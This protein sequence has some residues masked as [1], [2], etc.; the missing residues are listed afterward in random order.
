VTPTI[1][2]IIPC[3]GHAE[4]LHGTLRGLLGQEAAKECEIIVVDS[5]FDRHVAAAVGTYPGVTLVRSREGLLP[6]D[7]RNLGADHA[8]G[9]YLAFTDADCI[10]DPGWIASAVA[11]LERGA[12]VV[13]GPVIDLTPT[14]PI[15]AADNLLQF[16]DFPET[17]PNGSATYFPGCNL[18]I[19]RLDFLALGGFPSTPQRAGEDILFCLNVTQRWPDGIQFDHEMRVCH[20]GRAGFGAFLQHHRTFGFARGALGLFLRPVHKRY[21]RWAIVIPLVVLKRLTYIVGR[22]ARWRASALPRVIV[23]S[24]LLVMGLVAW[25]LGF[26]EGLR[27][28]GEEAR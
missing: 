21:G 13:G 2:V 15:G 18:A 22:T 16:V 26:R 23:L 3:R 11:S 17:R 8:R 1:S 14:P 19:R 20:I 7:A 5:A 24:P 25:S 10:P 12:R 6:G 4:L 28:T 27:S 9:D